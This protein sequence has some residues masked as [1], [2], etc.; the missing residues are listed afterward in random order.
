M[1]V[2]PKKVQTIAMKLLPKITALVTAAMAEEG[3]PKGAKLSVEEMPAYFDTSNTVLRAVFACAMQRAFED[4]ANRSNIMNRFTTIDGWELFLNTHPE[5][6]AKIAKEKAEKEAKWKALM[7]KEKN[8][9][10]E[11]EEEDSND[12]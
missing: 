12:E 8:D 2:D 5:V 11:E 3:A 9:A 7:A 10:G 1:S 4:G 6:V